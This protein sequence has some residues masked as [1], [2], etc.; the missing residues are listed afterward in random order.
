MLH[1]TRKAF[2]S[3]PQP[4]KTFLGVK[5]EQRHQA[6]TNNDETKPLCPKEQTCISCYKSKSNGQRTNRTTTKRFLNTLTHTHIY[7]DTMGKKRGA[8]IRAKKRADEAAEEL[9]NQTIENKESAQYEAKSNEELFTIDKTADVAT[10]LAS[11]KT[12]KRSLRESSSSS[13]S[14]TS[15]LT[16]KQG[17]KNRISEMDERKIHE[18]L[19]KHSKEAIIDL[20]NA[21]EER[22][23]QRKRMKRTAGTAK[24]NFD[25]WGDGDNH[26]NKN[27]GSTNKRQPSGKV[28]GG[29][30]KII[31]VKVGIASA[32]GTA[33][34]IFKEVSKASLRKDIQQPAAI[35]NKELKRKEREKEM[36]RKTV[37][38][39]LAQPGQSYRPDEEQHQDVIGEALGIELRRKEAEEYKSAPI[40]GGRMNQRTLSLLI[41]S[42]D[43]ESSDDDGDEEDNDDEN[44]KSRA[45]SLKRKEKLTRAQRNKQK[46]VRAM[47]VE[48]EERK[49]AK[50]FL[51]TFQ[52]AKKI[53]KEIKK[54]EAEH[55]ARKQ[56]INALKE[57]KLSKPL[58]VNIIDQ[59]SKL[60]PI[61]APSLPVA[62]TDELKD[63][64]L[65][66]IKPKGSLLTDRVESMI[67]RKMAHRKTLEKKRIVNGKRRNMK[68]GKGREFLLA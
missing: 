64:S 6:P 21:N 42:S 50:Q 36:A 18:M 60:D 59:I 1:T 62:L 4:T 41:H 24:A 22:M 7:K 45:V 44:M 46:R 11:Q 9:L 5:I 38:I 17:K 34:I 32:A 48:L 23:K 63:G 65:R 37:Q 28:N 35:S 51:H 19:K 8:V 33:P 55:I 56:E 25:L 29:G 67:S 47:Q 53:S 12:K 13:T 10:A 30:T 39:E 26:N 31:P 58:G 14:S 49:K 52:D 54:K 20:A 2:L 40:G 27:S 43:E 57:E 15:T 68:G 61:N 16:L 3:V 66:T